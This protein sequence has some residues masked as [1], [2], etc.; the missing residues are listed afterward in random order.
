M[1]VKELQDTSFLMTD[2]LFKVAAAFKFMNTLIKEQPDTSFLMT[3]PLF[4]VAAAFKFM[5]SQIL[6]FD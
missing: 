4:K 2:P 3:D 1:F 6:Y 5:N